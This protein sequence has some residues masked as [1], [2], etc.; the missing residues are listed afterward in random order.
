MKTV[1][2]PLAFAAC[3]LLG[4]GQALPH[5][6]QPNALP[7]AGRSTARSLAGTVLAAPY[8]VLR[9]PASGRVGQVYVSEGQAVK[10]G[11]VL[12]KLTNGTTRPRFVVAP[13]AGDVTNFHA[14]TGDYVTA[15][16]G[17]ARLTPQGPVRI[18][19]AAVAA[20][21]LC[22]GDS[23]RVLTGPVGLAG[24]CTPLT[25]VEPDSAAATVVLVLGRQGWPPGTSTAVTLLPPQPRAACH[26]AR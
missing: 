3:G 24:V 2:M 19:V 12:L 26:L 14:G 10:N 13:A 5:A 16:A 8:Q 20:A 18:R 25:A 17:Y 6:D 1:L 21:Q 15:G 9:L 4:L 23:L 22:P 7:A 11:Q